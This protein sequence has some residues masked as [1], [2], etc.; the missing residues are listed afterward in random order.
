[1]EGKSLH[2]PLA[3]LRV[4]CEAQ[5]QLGRV[6]WCSAVAGQDF[7]FEFLQVRNRDRVWVNQKIRRKG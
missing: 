5:Q 6:V 7:F 2:C 4:N 3:H 1:M